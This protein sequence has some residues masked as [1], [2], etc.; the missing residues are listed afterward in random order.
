ISV[1]R[2]PQSVVELRTSLDPVRANIEDA[3]ALVH[4]TELPKDVLR[5]IVPGFCRAALEASFTHVIR[6]RG[7]AAGRTH[8][9]IEDDLTSAGKPARLAALAF[10]GDKDRGGDVM[11][12]LNQFGAWAGDTF[13]ACKEGAHEATSTDLSLLIK[14]TEK[15][16]M[17]V[18][19]EVK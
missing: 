17:R 14:D 19:A 13:R 11:G 3:L 4:T 1:T 12:R 10:Y 16:A 5:R 7:L 15:L 8:A 2:R 18:I 6:R 9:D